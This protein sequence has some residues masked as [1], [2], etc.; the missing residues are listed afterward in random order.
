LAAAGLT[1]RP[2]HG[3]FA[4]RVNAGDARDAMLELLGPDWAVV[5]GGIL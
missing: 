1:I 3:V 2:T 5:A 4:D